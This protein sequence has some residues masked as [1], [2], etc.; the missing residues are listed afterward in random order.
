MKNITKALVTLLSLVSFLSIASPV[1]AASADVTKIETFIK[2]VIQVLVVL[3]GLISAG[4]FVYGGIGYITSS[5]NPESLDRSKKTIFYSAIGLVI[6]LGAFV[7]TNII[8]DLATGA[9]GTTQ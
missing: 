9:F 6:V 2:S 5:G 7:L 3:A 4:F 8:S 1:F